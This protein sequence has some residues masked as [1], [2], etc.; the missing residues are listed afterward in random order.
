MWGGF[1]VVV[2]L[3]LRP[4]GQHA[5]RC[6]KPFYVKHLRLQNPL[7][8]PLKSRHVEGFLQET[9]WR[10][11]LRRRLLTGGIAV[12]RMS[13]KRGEMQLTIPEGERISRILERLKLDLED[14]RVIMVGG[15]PI[16]D[17]AAL[18]EGDRLALFP[19]ALAFNNY[20]AINFYNRLLRKN[21]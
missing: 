1:H 15:R 21:Q 20:V 5:L 10:K 3:S 18:S 17:D 7:R 14:V 6:R 9:P 19:P 12:W 16:T 11:T 13:H 4:P 2:V 8:T